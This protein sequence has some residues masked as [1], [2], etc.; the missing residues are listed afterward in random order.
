[1]TLERG[2]EF[3]HEAVRSREERYAQLITQ[4]L[5]RRRRGTLGKSWYVDETYIKV[6]AKW[7]SLYQAV[8]RSGALVDCRLS[9]QRNM[10]AAKQFFKEALD[11]SGDAPDRVTTDKEVS[12]PRAI[13]GELGESVLRRTNQYLNNLIEQDHR[14]I[15]RRY[16]PMKGF[17]SLGSASRFCRAHDELRNYYE[18]GKR[19]EKV[20]LKQQKV[21]YLN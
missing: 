16:G 6:K 10:G 14:G 18:V 9:E 5:R 3:T 8:D 7:R 21:S 4:H 15:K 2:F 19:G 13:R 12:Y 11:L 20:S 17:N 1:M